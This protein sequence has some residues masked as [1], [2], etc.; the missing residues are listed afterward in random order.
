MLPKNIEIYKPRNTADWLKKKEGTLGGSEMAA[1]CGLNPWMTPRDVWQIKTGRKSFG[2]P[3][4]VMKRGKFFESGL[5]CMWA[6]E[7]GNR[8]IK[9]S[10]PDILYIDKEYPFLSVTPDCRYFSTDGGKRTLEA[11]T[12][13][14]RYDDPL[15]S[16]KIQHTWEMGFTGDTHGEIVWEYPQPTICFKSQTNTFDKELFLQLKEIAIEFWNVNVLQDIEPA[17]ITHSDIEDKFPRE[18][19]GKT[20][21]CSDSL[22]LRHDEIVT[23]QSKIN[24]TT[25]DLDSKKLEVKFFMEDAEKA[26]YNDQV[27]FTWKRN[28]NNQRIFKTIKQH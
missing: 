25:E 11:K 24:E 4:M 17:L 27:L 12:T 14:G 18:T 26:M 16:W 15:D 9:S 23:L 22:A 3:T 21:D 5:I 19:V 6:D 8:I 10:L 1:I 13:F 2:E 20:V 28:K 7:T